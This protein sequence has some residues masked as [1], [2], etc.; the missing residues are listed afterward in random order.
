MKFSKFFLTLVLALPSS[1]YAAAGA[2]LQ[3]G[4]VSF[5]PGVAPLWVASDRKLF[6]Q[7]GVDPSWFSSGRHPPCLRR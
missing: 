1:V 4:Y 5:V 2:R 3:I 7:E 6:A